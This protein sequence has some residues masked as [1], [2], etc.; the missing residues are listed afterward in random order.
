M[1]VVESYY[2]S[3]LQNK[4]FS[5][6]LPEST[7]EYCSENIMAYRGFAGYSHVRNACAAAACV[8]AGVALVT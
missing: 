5:F 8:C 7:C 2:V 1:D 3:L 6:H 4:Y